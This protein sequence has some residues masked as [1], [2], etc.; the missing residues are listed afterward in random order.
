MR[1]N[2]TFGK[3]GEITAASYLKDQGLVIIKQNWKCVYGEIDIIAQMEKLLI[4]VEVKTRKDDQYGFPEDAITRK[5][6][7]HLIRAAML[8]IGEYQITDDWRI[9]IISVR[10][11]NG[12]KT[13][14]EW[15]ENA[16]RD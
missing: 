13:E 12:Q 5:K 1:Y 10:K 7:E 4:F 9:D 8:Y 2:Q 14:I 3:W 16:I 15:F 6:R 11:K